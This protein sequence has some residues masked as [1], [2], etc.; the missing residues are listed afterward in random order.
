[1]DISKV[2]SVRKDCLEI[3][4]DHHEELSPLKG[5]TLVITGGTGFLGTWISE[6]IATLNDEY[7]YG[8]QLTLIAR[9]TDHF[10]NAKKHLAERKDVHLIKS[11][12]RNLTELPKETDWLVHAASNPDNRF[13]ATNPIETMSAIA[14]GTS[15]VLRAA[16]RCEN[17]K[18]FLNVS[19]GLI[20]GS[21]PLEVKAVAET[22][23]GAPVSGSTASAYAAAK[24]YAE[25]FVA[26]A[27][28]Q[29]QIPCMSVRPFAFLGPYQSLETPWALNNFLHDALAGNPVRVF[30][31]GQS[32]RSYLYGSDAAF[33]ILKILTHGQSGDCYN[34]G[35]A[36]GVSLEQLARKIAS[37]FD[38]APEIRLKT[39]NTVQQVSSFVP[40]LS[41]AIKKHALEVKVSLDSALKK[42]IQWHQNKN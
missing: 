1:M 39:S 34:V 17:I 15:A 42:T 10:K 4:E 37:C 6:V 8:T 9:G 33:W 26:A 14:D 27:R 2:T 5:K 20:Y 24:R 21:L 30:G 18:M 35:S 12:V 29:A 23:N 32:V 22:Y 25:T 11:D 40:D 38:P 3:L 13:H 31:D 16:D 41:L 19:S 28:T 36:E 7:S